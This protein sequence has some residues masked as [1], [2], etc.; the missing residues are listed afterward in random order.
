MT[1]SIEVAKAV[2]ELSNRGVSQAKIAAHLGVSD[3]YV[4]QILQANR[5]APTTMREMLDRA[6]EDCERR[7]RAE[8]Q[9][10]NRASGQKQTVAAKN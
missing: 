9:N 8:R 6:W 10:G 7:H 3:G 4:N 5:P 1:L 2:T